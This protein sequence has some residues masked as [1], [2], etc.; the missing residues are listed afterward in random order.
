[1]LLIATGI[2]VS[3]AICKVGALLTK[4]FGVSGG[5]LP[6]ITAVVVVLA[7]V[8]PSQF[9]R[10]AP[11]GEAMALILM[12]VRVRENH[13]HFHFQEQRKVSEKIIHQTTFFRSGVLHCDRC[14]RK[15]MECDKHCAE[16]ILV[17]IGPDWDTSCCD[18]GGR[19][20]AQRGAKVAAFGIK[21]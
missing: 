16:H 15:H 9:G 8:F 2:A 1:M 5:S 3:L 12:Q 7:T 17:C 21:C 4:H 20:A 18:I 13:T 19:E 10:L 6:A 11:S 14:E